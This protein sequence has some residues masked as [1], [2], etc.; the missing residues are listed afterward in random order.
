MTKDMSEEK[1]I[2]QDKNILK[3]WMDRCKEL[4]SRLKEAVSKGENLCTAHGLLLILLI[5]KHDLEQ[6][7]S[8]AE[9]ETEKWKENSRK[10]F[11]NYVALE[12]RLS[13][14]MDVGGKM[15][16]A[17]KKISAKQPLTGGLCDIDMQEIAKLA[18]AEWDGI[19][20]EVI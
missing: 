1:D 17:L 15:V 5:E 18:L 7:L 4:E 14:L 8:Q 6:R 12:K 3:N 20:K 16:G 19:K 13:H 11:A 9:A 2:M 10:Y